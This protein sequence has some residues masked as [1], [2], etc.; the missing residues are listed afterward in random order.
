[1]HAIMLLSH[2]KFEFNTLLYFKY[3]YDLVEYI[4]KIFLCKM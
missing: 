2:F 4:I 3:I 1:M